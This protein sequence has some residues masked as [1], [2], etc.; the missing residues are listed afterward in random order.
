MPKQLTPNLKE[1]RV[2]VCSE[3]LEAYE[4]ERDGMFTNLVTGDEKCAYLYDPESKRHIQRIR[5][6][7]PRGS[8]I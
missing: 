6:G 3:L 1:R 5:P 4:A 2:E 8:V 7:T